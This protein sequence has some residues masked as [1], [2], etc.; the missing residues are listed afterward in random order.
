MAEHKL[1]LRLN[2]QQLE[3]LDRTVASGEAK[4]RNDLIHRALREY[5]AAHREKIKE[6]GK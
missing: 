5:T 1:V 3:L 2:Q 6:A 4:D